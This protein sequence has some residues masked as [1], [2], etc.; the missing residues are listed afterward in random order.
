MIVEECR[1]LTGRIAEK[2]QLRLQVDQLRRFQNVRSILSARA[3]RIAPL[4]EVCRTLRAAG[5]QDVR[6]GEAARTFAE[7][8]ASLRASFLERPESIVEGR[9]VF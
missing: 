9:T 1:N 5:I 8:L 2:K 4:L 7:S 6:L 3:Q